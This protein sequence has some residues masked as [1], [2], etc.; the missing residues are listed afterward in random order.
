MSGTQEEKQCPLCK[1]KLPK[2]AL[3]CPFCKHSFGIVSGSLSNFLKTIG[4]IIAIFIIAGTIAF[5][6]SI[7]NV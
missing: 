1:N 4:I 5:I 6:L 2:E 7:F 3:V